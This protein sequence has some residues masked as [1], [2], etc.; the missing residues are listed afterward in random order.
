MLFLVR[1]FP[2]WFTS[3]RQQLFWV[4]ALRRAKLSYACFLALQWIVQVSQMVRVGRHLKEHVV[5]T[6]LP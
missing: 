3:I 2:S 1:L 6:P 4:C 5:P